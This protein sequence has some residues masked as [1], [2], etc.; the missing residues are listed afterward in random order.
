MAIRY[1]TRTGIQAR[2]MY[3]TLTLGRFLFCLRFFVILVLVF[4]LFFRVRAP[5][6]GIK[7]RL[8]VEPVREPLRE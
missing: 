6:G 5:V 8:A 3:A 7:Q 2:E 1:A 4:V